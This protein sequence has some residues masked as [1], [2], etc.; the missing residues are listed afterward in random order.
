MTELTIATNSNQPTLPDTELSVINDQ[1][2]GPLAEVWGIDAQAVRGLS[3]ANRMVNLRHGFAASVPIIC[4]GDHCPYV[5]TCYLTSVERPKKGR[6]P[7]E[8]ATIIS[9]FERYCTSL[10]VTAKD[11]V[12]LGLIKE[13]VDIDIQ[14]IRADHKMAS[15]V[16]FVEKVVAAV[17]QDGVAHYRPELRKSVEY[18]ERLR[19]ER[20]RILGL[21]N[22]TRKDRQRQPGAVDPSSMAASLIAKALMLEKQ[23]RIREPEIIDITPQPTELDD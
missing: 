9:L 6:C 11:A 14:L 20:H 17:D 22:S 1:T 21:L 16:D 4:K 12:D 18:K 3:R 7:I 10:E 23:G 5:E 2:L 13:L 8:I 15:D 19:K